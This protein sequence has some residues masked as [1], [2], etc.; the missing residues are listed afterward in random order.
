MTICDYAVN[1]GIFDARMAGVGRRMIRDLLE[2][3]RDLESFVYHAGSEGT[4][5]K[6]LYFLQ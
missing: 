3:P 2:L 5:C 4:K 1:E 6:G